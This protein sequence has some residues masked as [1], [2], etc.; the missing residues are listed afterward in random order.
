MLKNALDTNPPRVIYLKQL[1]RK[2][3]QA[4]QLITLV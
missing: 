4:I 1:A 2:C 3:Q